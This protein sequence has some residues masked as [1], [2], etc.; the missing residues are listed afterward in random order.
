MDTDANDASRLFR[1][2]VFVARSNSRIGT[3]RLDPPRVGWIFCWGGVAAVL[4]LLGI[5]IFGAYTP[6]QKNSGTLVPSDGVLT[7][8]PK[9]GG[10]VTRVFVKAGDVVKA[11]QPILELSGEQSSV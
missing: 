1:M 9:S 11:Q 8:V 4:A 6:R 2:E 5:L 10:L 7:V 3:I